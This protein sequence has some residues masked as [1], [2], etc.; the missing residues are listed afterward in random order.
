MTGI[1]LT[2]DGKEV[3]RMF[4][5]NTSKSGF[6]LL[7]LLIVVIIVSLLA[8]VALPQFTR[9]REKVILSEAKT[10]VNALAK[11][12]MMYQT[13]FGKFPTSATQD[14]Q[15]LAENELSILPSPSIYW[16]YSVEGRSAESLG[17]C[18]TARTN[19]SSTYL[20]YTGVLIE[21]QEDGSWKFGWRNSNG[22]W[23]YGDSWPF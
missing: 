14:R 19:G 22:D 7:E 18:A 15:P 12:I 3:E 17:N 2:I 1:T 20:G 21:V 4:K 23:H 8:A 6:T 9:M 16:R 10:G 5:R 13:E 11:A